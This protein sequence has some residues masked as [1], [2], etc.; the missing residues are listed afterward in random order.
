VAGRRTATERLAQPLALESV[1]ARRV[2][3][4]LVG[5]LLRFDR[6]LISKRVA[7]RDAGAV[8]TALAVGHALGGPIVA[9]VLAVGA[10]NTSF[11]D[12]AVAVR[13]RLMRISFA[14]VAVA[15][16]A[17]IGPVTGGVPWLAIP[18][19]A[20]WA[21]GA[22]LAVCLGP[23]ATTVGVVSLVVFIVLGRT[24]LDPAHAAAI[25][26]LMLGGGAITMVFSALALPSRVSPQERALA[27]AYAHLAELARAAATS[28]VP[29]LSAPL[30][31][32]AALLAAF[33]RTRGAGDEALRT[34][35]DLAERLRVETITLGAWASDPALREAAD[36]SRPIDAALG[37]AARAYDALA[38]ALVRPLEPIDV[39]AE[40]ATLEAARD[41]LAT[42][43]PG[44]R[45]PL[46]G[47]AV[48]AVDALA[49]QLRAADRATHDVRVSG[50]ALARARGALRPPLPP[51][52][53]ALATVRANLTLD[54]TALRHALRLAVCIA[55]AEGLERGFDV[56]RGYWIPMTAALVLRPDF[57][58]TFTRGFLRVIGTLVGLA[59]AFPLDALFG[60]GEVGRIVLVFAG[61]FATRSLG[62][63]HYGALTASVTLVVAVLL[64]YI[65]QAPGVTLP[66]RAIATLEGGALG[67]GFYL[68]WPTWERRLAPAVLAALLD[69]YARYWSAIV[70]LTSTRAEPELDRLGE[71]RLAARL[72]RSNAEASIAR[73]RAEP[74]R[75]GLVDCY[76]GI[77][78]AAHRFVVSGIRLEA[79]RGSGVAS[80]PAVAAFARDI[81]RTVAAFA[82]TLR[83][84]ADLEGLPDLRAGQ[85][86]LRARAASDAERFFAAEA[87]GIA[88]ALD[89]IASLLDRGARLRHASRRFGRGNR[90]PVP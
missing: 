17:G 59:I 15:L 69:A 2:T 31:D 21:F 20:A 49:G 81:E 90:S 6:S 84:G 86:A 39:S 28:D 76:V 35:L 50:G 53:T 63:S 57:T 26:L 46:H 87:D 11:A 83:A 74:G 3:H 64:T 79:L 62:R 40:L 25:A 68:L 58:E 75:G 47:A 24:P 72:A 41:A 89:T 67:L 77:L 9:V 43:A 71:I 73:M 82:T 8:A 1:S 61:V 38:L 65:G 22:G 19:I 52:R 60:G 85:R 27:A 12:A 34:L 70:E 36:W 18:A 4:P 10:L 23:D 33:G 54:S 44:A 7:L 45:V 51:V 55:C 5:R 48:R 32:A 42:G 16:A 14:S 88:D 37:A 66:E 29:P 13:V 78:A 80:A 30:S 56:Q